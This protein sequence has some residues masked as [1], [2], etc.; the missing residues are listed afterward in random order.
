VRVLE[1]Q[2]FDRALPAKPLEEAQEVAVTDTHAALMLEL[3]D[4]PEGAESR[5][6][7]HGTGDAAI[8]AVQRARRTERGGF[9]QAF[10][11][12]AYAR[13]VHYCNLASCS[14]NGVDS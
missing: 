9:E 14:M 4:V 13:L 1:A 11:S 5:M 2:A 6:A 8:R 3:A 10:S 7:W 12:L